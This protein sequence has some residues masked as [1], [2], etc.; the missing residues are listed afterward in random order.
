MDQPITKTF[1]P[2]VL[3]RIVDVTESIVPEGRKGLQE[4]F[5]SLTFPLKPARIACQDCESAASFLPAPGSAITPTKHLHHTTPRLIP[6]G[7][8]CSR[9]GGPISLSAALAPL[10]VRPPSEAACPLLVAGAA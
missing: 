9:R 5:P 10:F 3:P 4:W 6:L 1:I 7:N 8:A 2:R